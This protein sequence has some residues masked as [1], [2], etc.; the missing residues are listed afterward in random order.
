MCQRYPAGYTCFCG[1][2]CHKRGSGSRPPPSGRR[3]SVR[4]RLGRSRRV[5]YHRAMQSAKRVRPLLLLVV[6]AGCQSSSTP[7]PQAPPAPVL[8]GFVVIERGPGARYVIDTRGQVCLLMIEHATTTPVDCAAL[9]KNVKGAAKHLAWLTLTPDTT[10]ASN[11]PPRA[12]RHGPLRAKI[13]AG[14]RQTG[15]HSYEIARDAVDLL[16]RNPMV[17]SRQARIVPSI[18]NGKP[19]GI[20][21]YAIRPDSLFTKLGLRNGDTIH[22]INGHELTSP[23]KA[24]EI[25]QQA[26]S[27]SKLVLELTRRQQPV[28][29]TITIAGASTPAPARPPVTTTLKDRMYE[30]SRAYDRQDF[31]NARRIAVEVLATDPQNIR[32]LRIAVSSACALRDA[33]SAKKHHARLPPRDQAHMRIRCSRRG[34]QLDN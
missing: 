29:V 6:L 3:R 14:I 9:K 18:K 11:D 20:K 30:A 4:R 10:V 12:H 7:S 28:S 5:C 34:I 16:L 8:D 27:A 13:Y 32:M 19:N 15:P 17:I 21:M 24:L 25:Y 22:R 26:K 31:D 23:D 2:C 33:A 1:F